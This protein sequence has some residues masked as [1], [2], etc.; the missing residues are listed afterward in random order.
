MIVKQNLGV[1]QQENEINLSACLEIDQ[2]R[3]RDKFVSLS[4][5]NQSRRR[6]K[7]VSLSSSGPIETT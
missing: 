7:F 5:F 6:D 4:S 3:K 2:S 1:T